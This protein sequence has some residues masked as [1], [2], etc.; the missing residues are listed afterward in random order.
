M[1]SANQEIKEIDVVSFK[2]AIEDWPA[3]TTGTVV[4]DF[5][6]DKMVEISDDDGQE[7]ELFGVA[8]ED[9]ELVQSFPS[10]PPFRVPRW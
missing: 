4:A 10:N 3:G 9:L 1:T 7:L 2:E 8:E 5:G 6:N